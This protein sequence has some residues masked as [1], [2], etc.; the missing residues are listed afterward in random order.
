M[1]S[2]VKAIKKVKKKVKKVVKKV[3]KKNP[4]TKVVKKVA[5]GIK[6]LGKKTWEGI[7]KF[8][9]SAMT[10]FAKF[11][12]KIGPI[13]MMALSF[14]MPWM[15]GGLGGMASTAWGNLG[16]FLMPGGVAPGFASGLGGAMKTLG[17]Y[18][19][20][21]A[22]FVGST[23][24]G[25]TQTLSKTVGS[26]GQGNFSEG[27]K[28]LVGGTGDVLSGRAGMGTQ[29]LVSQTVLTGA[30]G[31]PGT[32]AAQVTKATG[33]FVTSGGIT[34]GAA[35]GVVST[36]GVNMAVA[37]AANA[38]SYNIL[39]AAW[40]KQGI[41]QNMTPDAQR[42]HNTI[43]QDYKLDDFSAHEYTKN[44]GMT[45]T[46]QVTGP[47]K[48]K[49]TWD[50]DYSSS[51]DFTVSQP[52]PHMD[53]ATQY[54]YTGSKAKLSSTQGG[55]GDAS[56]WQTGSYTSVGDA[57]VYD[58][59]AKAKTSSLLDKGK[60]KALDYA[61]SYLAADNQEDAYA[62]YSTGY[63]DSSLEAYGASYGDSKGSYNKSGSLLTKAL[64]DGFDR[65]KLDIQGSS[66]YA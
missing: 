65:Q 6:K 23:Y 35:S 42:Y 40:S 17:S 34:G 5:K 63:G 3:V 16:S 59:S 45:S 48:T 7:K 39:N 36:G 2:V 37:N 15:M 38:Q 19:Y 31:A 12:N 60:T 57:P 8:G 13:G 51:G 18:A 53:S 58:I 52:N 33:N 64:Q 28:N 30:R 4:I 66:K 32:I 54:S 55:V 43:K 26:F 20:K 10:K 11:S 21:G 14:A 29:K 44:N 25:I 56:M 9:K 50:I 1:G 27:F 49:T 41:Y 62:S 61:S 22:Q 24:K 46:T 47:G